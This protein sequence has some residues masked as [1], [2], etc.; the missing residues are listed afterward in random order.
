MHFLCSP[1]GSSGDIHPMLG[2]A[3]A[4]KQRGH[5]VTFIVNGYF[6]EVVKKYGVDF[7]ELGTKE[8]FLKSASH[9]DLWNPMRA[10]QHIWRSL[11]EPSLRQQYNI[12]ADLYR[13]GETIG[14]VN[15]FGLGGLVAQDKIGIPVITAHIQPA[16]VWSAISPPHMPGMFGPRWMQRCQYRIGERF[17]ID[18]VVCPDLNRFREELGL[19]PVKQITRWWHSKWCVACLFPEWYCPPQ[20]D[21]PANLIQTDFPLWDEPNSKG[22]PADVEAFL[23]SGD[24]PIA[25]TPGSSNVFGKQFFET[26][27]AVCDRL[28]RRGILLTRFSEQIPENLPSSV[29]HF[30]YVP[31]SEL[32]PRSAAVVHHGGIGSTAQG[33]AAGVPQLLMPLAHD[34]FDNAERLKRFGVGDWLKPSKFTPRTVTKKLAHLLDSDAVRSQCAELRDKLSNKDGLHRSALNIEK[35][36]DKSGK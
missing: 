32:L 22:L 8:A 27:V 33:L 6:E 24:P 20:S 31:F 3:L 29:Q 17:F 25:F 13:P 28:Q 26:A 4:L 16:V 5:R 34:Q 30:L 11:V 35:F 23:I 14:I 7:V 10:F 36:V 9:P 1:F 19:A 2:L 15:C 18:P 12:F 21:W